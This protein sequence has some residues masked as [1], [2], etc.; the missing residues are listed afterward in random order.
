M[1]YFGISSHHWHA[2]YNTLQAKNAKAEAAL[3][4]AEQKAH[5][6]QAKVITKVVTQYVDR[7]VK[8]HEKGATIVKQVPVFVPSTTPDFPPGFRVLHDSAAL[9]QAPPTTIPANAAPVPAQTATTTI[10]ENYTGCRAN[11]A[12]VIALQEY[13]VGTLDTLGVKV[14]YKPPEFT[15]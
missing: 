4:V 2:K 14:D 1:I 11:A 3:I 8:I 6:A 5:D 7:V 15:P 10:I 13:I 9:G 12:Q